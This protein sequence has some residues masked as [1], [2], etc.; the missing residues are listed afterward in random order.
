MNTR[1]VTAF[2]LIFLSLTAAC[3]PA[4]E[5]KTAAPKQR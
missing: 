5:V 4:A 2:G 3:P 1:F